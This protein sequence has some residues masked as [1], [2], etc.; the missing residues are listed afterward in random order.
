[1]VPWIP[2]ALSFQACLPQPE[3]ISADMV[4]EPTAV[5]ATP[6]VSIDTSKLLSPQFSKPQLS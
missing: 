6:A 3:F 2:Q 1:M 4:T 5:V